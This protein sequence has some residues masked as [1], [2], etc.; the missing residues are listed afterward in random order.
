[1]FAPP[2]RRILLTPCAGRTFLLLWVSYS[3][4]IIPHIVSPP[5]SWASFEKFRR[6]LQSFGR[7]HSWM[8]VLGQHAAKRGSASAV[9]ASVMTL[10]TN[11]SRV[12]PPRQDREPLSRRLQ[13]PPSATA[14]VSQIHPVSET[15]PRTETVS[16]I[17]RPFSNRM[18]EREI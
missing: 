13:Q 7:G 15:E 18:V 5:G 6:L 11:K 10:S 1:M 12:Q 14:A 4:W 17:R 3:R 2:S 8:R 16:D 9:T